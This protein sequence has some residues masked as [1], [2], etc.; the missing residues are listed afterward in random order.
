MAFIELEDTEDKAEGVIFSSRYEQVMNKLKE[1]L[2]VVIAAK[3]NFRSGDFSLIVE[4][5]IMIEEFNPSTEIVINITNEK[6][7]EKLLGLKQAISSNPGNYKLRIIYGTPLERKE[8]VKGID[9]TPQVLEV[10]ER[11]RY[12]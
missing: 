5:I 6:D 1:N 12:Q 8:L 4:D 9:P 10:I 11:Y 2:P 3:A 7:K